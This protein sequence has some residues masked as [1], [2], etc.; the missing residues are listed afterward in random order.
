MLPG[1]L[2]L[3][4][5]TMLVGVLL[6][7]FGVRG[8]T[9][10]DHPACRQCHFDL[11]GI[12]P[13]VVTCPECGAGLKRDNA[14]LPGVRKKMP[15]LAALGVL[16]VLTPLVPVGVVAFAALTDRNINSFKPLGL[17]MWEARHAD[18]KS[19]EKLVDE[20]MNRIL[21]QKLSASQYDS[22]INSILKMQG[23]LATP[24]QEPWGSIIERARVDGSIK[25]NQDAL[26]NQQSAVLAMTSRQT[27]HAGGVLPVRVKLKETRIAPSTLES[28][29]VSLA[30][31]KIDGRPI[32][33]RPEKHSQGDVFAGQGFTIQ[34]GFFGNVS[35]STDPYSMGTIVLQ[36]SRPQGRFM[37]MGAPDFDGT[38]ALDLPG[39]LPPGKHTVE[40][41]LEL[42]PQSA[43]QSGMVRVNGRLQAPGPQPEASHVTL[44]A[45]IDVLPESVPVATP[46]KLTDEQRDALKQRLA[47]TNIEATQTSGYT[48]IINGVRHTVEPEFQASVQFSTKDL[49]ENIAYDV[50]ICADGKEQKLGELTNGTLADQARPDP[51][52][53]FSFTSVTIINGKVTRSS[54]S[55]SNAKDQRTVSG[56]IDPINADHAD[57]ILRPSQDVAASTLDLDSYADAEIVLKN[58]PIQ[59]GA[60]NAMDPW[61]ASGDPF[62]GMNQRMQQQQEQMMRDL[63]RM[64]QRFNPPPARRAPSQPATKPP[65]TKETTPSDGPA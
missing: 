37:G 8:R 16:L 34:Q 24:W 59:Q 21:S 51:N 54:S 14:V 53:M 19:T 17:L 50:F 41:N 31:A 7:L 60:A 30:S 29:D 1:V 49:P 46:K 4:L 2:V 23:D 20:V 63:Q 3:L 18:A 32:D 12:F 62:A 45:Q 35:Q 44:T 27:L 52:S 6:V 22:V 15:L 56:K 43:F 42:T 28:L 5:V 57:I 33:R 36:G 9:I 26:F 25:P 48:A 11:L 55:D 47:P 39:D 64:Q 40:L 58:V 13:E 10:N 65:A 38:L 61:G